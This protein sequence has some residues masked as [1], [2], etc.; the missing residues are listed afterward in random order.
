M[1]EKGDTSSQ[2]T[3]TH[4]AEI[5]GQLVE[6]VLGKNMAMTYNF[7][8]QTIDMPQGHKDQAVDIANIQPAFSGPLTAR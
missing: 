6:K 2:E 1:S 8:D 3:S 7:D 4:W 5:M